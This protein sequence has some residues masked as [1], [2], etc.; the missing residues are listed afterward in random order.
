MVESTII[1]NA[2]VTELTARGTPDTIETD[3]GNRISVGPYK[4]I[5]LLVHVSAATQNDVIRV[6]AGGNPPAFRG[7][8]GSKD[9]T[10]AGGAAELYM[11][12][13]TSRFA[14]DDGYIHIT[15]PTHVTL[16]GTLEAYGL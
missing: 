14:D 16:A 3:L 15:F 5:L 6:V 12:L 4:K 2:R 10:C 13:D 8:M 1:Q 7:G 9:Y 11:W